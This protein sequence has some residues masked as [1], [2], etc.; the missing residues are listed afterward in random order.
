M[1]LNRKEYRALLSF[2]SYYP[3]KFCEEIFNV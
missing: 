3:D 1:Y 2:Y